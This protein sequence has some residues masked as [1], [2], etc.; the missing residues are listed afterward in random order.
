M[1][2]SLDI[3]GRLHSLPS[4]PLISPPFLLQTF[5]F[6]DAQRQ[7]LIANEQAQTS[8]LIHRWGMSNWF[9]RIDMRVQLR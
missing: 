1:T 9:I 3:E 5:F 6:T 2:L 8:F 7:D 4:F